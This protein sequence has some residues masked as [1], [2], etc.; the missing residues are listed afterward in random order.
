MEDEGFW[1]GHWLVGSWASLS[2]S[3]L[4]IEGL[5]NGFRVLGFGFRV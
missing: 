2:G 4:E 5:A 1:G 3:C